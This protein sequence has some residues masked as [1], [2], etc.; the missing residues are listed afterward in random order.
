MDRFL[1]LQDIQSSVSKLASSLTAKDLLA[2]F[3]VASASLTALRV[4]SFFWMYL[5]PS[6][7]SR[8]H[9]GKEPYALITGASDG[10]GLDL[11]EELCAKGFNIILHGRNSTKLNAVK[12]HLS[13]K[14]PS[15][16]FKIL[17][18]DVVNFPSDQYENLIAP[19]KDLNITI[20]VNNVGGTGGVTKIP[21]RTF[22][23]QPH[24]T[25]D[26]LLDFN[27]RF[28][29]HLTKSIL[30][31][32]MRSE[33]ALIIQQGSL[34]ALGVPYLQTYSGTKGFL[35]SW[36]R[37][38]D[39]ELKYGEKRDIEILHLDIGNVSTPENNP[40]PTDL[41]KPDSKT[42]AKAIVRRVGCGS[43]TV[44]PYFWHA[45]LMKMIS[46]LGDIGGKMSI[47]IVRPMV[48]KELEYTAGFQA[49][50]R[51]DK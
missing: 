32:L 45:V 11:A 28:M 12:S 9:H 30:P 47:D 46:G 37:A 10:I 6:K 2:A 21:A 27:V 39:V 17:V 44:A 19:I 26:A 14:Y 43:W 18:A 13:S 8:F 15:L 31:T 40:G 38:L 49:E 24:E 42:L 25:L 33:P 50:G 23:S 4:A 20:L 22:A 34:A 16:S 36:S 7:L 5:R 35:K 1:S 29:I 51:K 48:G 41:M 3:G